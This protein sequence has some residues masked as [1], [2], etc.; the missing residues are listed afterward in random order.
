MQNKNRLQRGIFLTVG[1]EKAGVSLACAYFLRQAFLFSQNLNA[2]GIEGQQRATWP[3]SGTA[4]RNSHHDRSH[5][6]STL[7]WYR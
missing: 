7:A 4:K 5:V 2:A 1:I 6:Y 3:W